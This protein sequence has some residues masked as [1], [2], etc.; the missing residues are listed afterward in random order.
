[1]YRMCCVCGEYI[2][3]GASTVSAEDRY[4][5]LLKKN[6]FITEGA[7]CCSDHTIA[8]H[9]KSKAIE[10]IA[11]FSIR[12]QKLNAGDIQLLLSK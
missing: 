3:G 12:M 7:R 6:V 11:P 2:A 8:H 9:L 5:V 1:M 10:Q 4:F